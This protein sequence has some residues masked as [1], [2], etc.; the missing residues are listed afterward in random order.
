MQYGGAVVSTN[1]LEKE[2]PGFESRCQLGHF[3]MFSLCLCEFLSQS[4]HSKHML[5][6]LIGDSELTIGVHACQ[7]LLALQQT[8]SLSRVYP[9]SCAVTGF[10]STAILNCISR[11]KYLDGCSF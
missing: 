9:A 3:F 2:D 1:A 6:R 11:R 4:H 5:V 8:G 10:G 7:S